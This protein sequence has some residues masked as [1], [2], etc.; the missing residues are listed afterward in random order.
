MDES[1]ALQAEQE[2]WD[3][4]VKNDPGCRHEERALDGRCAHCSRTDDGERYPGER[5]AQRAV[6]AGKW[7][8]A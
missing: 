2:M 4:I 1:Y 3:E 6:D 8:E 5:A 7:E